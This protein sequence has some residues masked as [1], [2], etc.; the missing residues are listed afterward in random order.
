[1]KN[2]FK[3]ITASKIV[4]SSLINITNSFVSGLL[5]NKNLNMKLNKYF[6]INFHEPK[7]VTD[8]L[9]KFYTG[10]RDRGVRFGQ[11]F[12]SH[13]RVNELVFSRFFLNLFYFLY[14]NNFKSVQPKF[15]NSFKYFSF[16]KKNKVTFL[17][18]KFLKFFVKQYKI[19]NTI[20][21]DSFNKKQIKFSKRG[22]LGRF[23]NLLGSSLVFIN[24]FIKD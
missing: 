6:F 17:G 22:Y 23:K 1:L 13:L 19:F 8:T 11:R 7:L 2:T 21:L 4:Y 5:K 18:P 24:D 16:L 14:L 10:F 15:S 3:F 20:K 9:D 12:S